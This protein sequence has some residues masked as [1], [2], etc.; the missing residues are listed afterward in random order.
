VSSVFVDGFASVVRINWIDGVRIYFANGDVA[1]IRAS[2][3]APQLR[4]YAVANTQV[5]V[6]ARECVKVLKHACVHAGSCQ[7]DC[8]DGDCRAERTVATARGSRIKVTQCAPLVHTNTR[9]PAG[10]IRATR[11]RS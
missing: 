2:G 7:C 1:H 6:C 9:A 10:I 3:N 8:G 5:G 4:C 11:Q